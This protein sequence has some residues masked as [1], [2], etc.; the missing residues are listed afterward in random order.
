[1]QTN[2]QNKAI[3]LYASA[4]RQKDPLSLLLP[5]LTILSDPHSTAPVVAAI[6]LIQ[7]DAVIPDTPFFRQIEAIIAADSAHGVHLTA[8]DSIE[9]A[10]FD[11]VGQSELTRKE[12]SVWR[13]DNP[14]NTGGTRFVRPSKSDRHNDFTI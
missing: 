4:K 3:R 9:T 14:M 6:R 11:L 2:L 5:L 12:Y 13:K 8:P 7:P 10:D 1:M